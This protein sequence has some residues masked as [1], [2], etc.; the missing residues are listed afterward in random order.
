MK[1]VTKFVLELIGDDF[2]CT[3]TLNEV[4]ARARFFRPDIPEAEFQQQ[5]SVACK[6]ITRKLV[7]SCR[8]NAERDL[9]ASRSEKVVGMQQRWR[10]A[11]SGPP[12]FGEF[13]LCLM[14]E[15]GAQR[16]RLGDF[17]EHY[18]TIWLPRYGKTASDLI[19]VVSVFQA[20]IGFKWAALAGA[21]VDGDACLDG[22]L[23]P[24][25]THFS[26][27]P[28]YSASKHWV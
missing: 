26:I 4:R 6:E 18:E 27:G 12:L 11:L 10:L 14:I 3:L 9:R 7:K 1:P 13:L 25:P 23:S 5:F 20:A 17:Q 15:V 24:R 28:R 22:P 2:A 16:E 8:V 19:Y 21:V